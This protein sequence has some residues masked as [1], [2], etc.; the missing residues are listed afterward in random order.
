[1]PEHWF[2]EEGFIKCKL[3]DLKIHYV[4]YKKNFVY[5]VKN[6]DHLDQDQQKSLLQLKFSLF[7]SKCF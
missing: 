7:D 6:D 3:L 2:L 5:A 4:E 1:M